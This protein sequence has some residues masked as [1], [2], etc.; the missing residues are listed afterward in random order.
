M[1]KK[2]AAKKQVL[3]IIEIADFCKPASLI[4]DT[5]DFQ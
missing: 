4:F 3:F 5:V 1:A 2:P